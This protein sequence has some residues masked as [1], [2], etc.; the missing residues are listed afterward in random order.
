MTTP[1]TLETRTVAIPLLRSDWATLQIPVRMAEDE[2]NQ[3]MAVLTA[4]KPGLVAKATAPPAADDD[5]APE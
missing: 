3:M 5:E 2:W 1:A 4:M